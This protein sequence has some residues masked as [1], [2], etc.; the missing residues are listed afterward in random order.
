MNCYVTIVHAILTNTDSIHPL[1]TLEFDCF[2]FKTCS[3]KQGNE[4]RIILD[5]FLSENHHLIFFTDV[6][7]I[8]AILVSTYHLWTNKP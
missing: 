6:Y 7:Y 5:L 8:A 1:N 3:N 2:G 4:N